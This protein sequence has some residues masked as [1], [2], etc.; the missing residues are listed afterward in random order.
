M[1]R[2]INILLETDNTT[3]VSY[4]NNMGGTKKLC[5]D[6]ARHTWEWCFER[7]IWIHYEPT[8]YENAINLPL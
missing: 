4:I 2:N 1:D 3:T 5:N 6:I 7:D 8:F